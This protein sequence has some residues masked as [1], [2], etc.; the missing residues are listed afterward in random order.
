MRAEVPLVVPEINWEQIEKHRGIIANPDCAAIIS[1]TPLWPIHQVNPITR[2][3]ISTYQAA[4]GAGA[5]AMNELRESTARRTGR[6]RL[7]AG[8]AA[9]SVRVQSLQPQHGDRSGNRLQRRRIQGDRGST[10][11]IR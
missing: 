11:D 8:G 4:S 3:I 7:R 2:L 9:A 5:A 6:A 1:I 10:Q